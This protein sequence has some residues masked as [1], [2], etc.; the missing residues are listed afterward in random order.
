MIGMPNDCLSASGG[1]YPNPNEARSPNVEA[2]FDIFLRCPRLIQPL[3]CEDSYKSF[4]V[5]SDFGI[6]HSLGLGTWSFVIN[7]ARSSYYAA[8]ENNM[9]LSTPLVNIV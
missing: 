6:R 1:K 2:V 7:R 5:P 9:Y 8:L 4:V 3:P